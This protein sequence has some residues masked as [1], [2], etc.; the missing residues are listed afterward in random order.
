[1]RSPRST[2]LGR[3]AVTALAVAL[4]AAG[5]SPR[6][7]SPARVY[8][9]REWQRIDRAETAGYSSARLDALRSWLRAN[10][11]TAIH[12]SL[13]GRTLFEYGDLSRVSKVASIRKSVLALMYGKYVAQG[14]IDLGDRGSELEPLVRVEQTIEIIGWL[15]AERRAQRQGNGERPH[16]APSSFSIALR[17]AVASASVAHRP[18]RPPLLRSGGHDCAARLG[19]RQLLPAGH[20]REMP[21]NRDPLARQLTAPR[22][23]AQAK[24]SDQS[25]AVC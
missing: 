19:C 25:P 21:L 17:S 22:A 2:I 6:A 23:V 11:T 16:R 9:A 15:G 1:M 14:V 13:G 7:Q 4:I 10:R 12:V 5:T 24:G 3:Q 20:A 8:P 18:S